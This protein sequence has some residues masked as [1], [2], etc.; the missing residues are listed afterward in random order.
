VFTPVRN[1][2]V[3]YQITPQLKV[4]AGR[5][6]ETGGARLTSY[7][8]G[9]GYSTRIANVQDGFMGL[10]SCSKLGFSVAVFSPLDKIDN[11]NV[12]VAYTMKDVAKFVG[13]YLG[14]KDEVWVGA[15][16]SA[17]ENL[18]VRVGFK[19]DALLKRFNH[20]SKELFLCKC[21]FCSTYH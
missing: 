17:I 15:D 2:S 20:Y 21:R 14:G 16:V 1:Y 19:N 9:N 6:R 12:G 18:T 10:V 5:L 13:G 7:I 8:D 3:S 11:T 4:L